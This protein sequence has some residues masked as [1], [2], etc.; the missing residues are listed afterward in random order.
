MAYWLGSQPFWYEPE[1]YPTPDSLQ[2]KTPERLEDVIE[3]MFQTSKQTRSEIETLTE[4]IKNLELEVEI[5]K[6]RRS[7]VGEIT[8][9]VLSEL[10]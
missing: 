1:Q 7:G 5:L 6:K 10:Q 8:N 2:K 3:E 4:R 9:I